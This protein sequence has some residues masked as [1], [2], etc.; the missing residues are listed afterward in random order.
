MVVAQ[1]QV[2][3][4]RV[5]DAQQQRIAE[6]AADVE[7]LTGE[8]DAALEQKTRFMYRL[9]ELSKRVG[10]VVSIRPASGAARTKPR[11]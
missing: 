3:H 9:Q 5:R 1:I 2:R 6:L 11:E 8:R 10:D 4:T 7:R